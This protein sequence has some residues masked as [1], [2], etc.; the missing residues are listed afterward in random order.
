M[1]LLVCC[2]KFLIIF[3][4]CDSDNL[5]RTHDIICFSP[6]CLQILLNQRRLGLPLGL[7]LLYSS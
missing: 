5:M 7:G 1:K 6:R 3:I 4:I 2:Y